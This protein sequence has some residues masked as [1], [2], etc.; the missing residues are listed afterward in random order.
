MKDWVSKWVESIQKQNH[1]ASLC[2]FLKAVS[3][4]VGSQE[5]TLWAINNLILYVFLSLWQA[6][7]IRNRKAI[8]FWYLFCLVCFS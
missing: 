8:L 7:F 2:N 4:L 3:P 1:I 5:R 6:D